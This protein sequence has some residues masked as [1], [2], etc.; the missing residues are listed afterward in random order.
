MVDSLYFLVMLYIGLY[1][2]LCNGDLLFC[3]FGTL[4]S[5]QTSEMPMDVPIFYV[6][7]QLDMVFNG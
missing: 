7:W 3:C 4:A 2:V 6:Q 5:K 1:N